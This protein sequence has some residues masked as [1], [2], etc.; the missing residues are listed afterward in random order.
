[1]DYK[2]AAQVALDVQDASNL[3]GVV[4]S[5]AGGVM[6]ALWEQARSTGQGTAWINKHPIC[7]L[8]GYKI[9][10]LNGCEPLSDWDNYKRASDM[11]VNI[12]G[13]REGV[14]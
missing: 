13:G 11:A 3:S 12:A 6:D 4:K 7:Y 5:F 8:F 9:M 10:S 2:R 14:Y 1:M